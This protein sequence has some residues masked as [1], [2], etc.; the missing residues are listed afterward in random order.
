MAIIK[1]DKIV[2]FAEWEPQTNRK[3]KISIIKFS[4]PSTEQSAAFYLWSLAEHQL[5]MHIRIAAYQEKDITEEEKKV[6]YEVGYCQFEHLD[7]KKKS[8]SVLKF[9]VHFEDLKLQVMQQAL[10][11]D[12]SLIVTVKDVD[13]EEKENEETEEIEGMEVLHESE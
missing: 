7:G 6:V 4:L 2:F 13:Y 5:Y 3:D 10:F 9:S 11:E 12:A 1:K 8:D